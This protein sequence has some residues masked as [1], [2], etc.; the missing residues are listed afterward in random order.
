MEQCII[1]N[2]VISDDFHILGSAESILFRGFDIPG[3]KHIRY[4]KDTVNI[5]VC[6]QSTSLRP[7]RDQTPHRRYSQFLTIRLLQ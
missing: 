3:G 6:L 1:L 2:A 7:E 5:L 4:G